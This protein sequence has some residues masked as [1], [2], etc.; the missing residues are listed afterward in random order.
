M[1]KLLVISGSAEGLT[2]VWSTTEYK[3]ENLWN[4]SWQREPNRQ[5]YGSHIS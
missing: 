2:I 4:M 5:K 1:T 3:P